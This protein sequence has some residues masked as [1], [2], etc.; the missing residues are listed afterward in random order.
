MLGQVEFHIYNNAAEPHLHTI[1]KYELRIDRY[2]NE[3]MK[4]LEENLGVNANTF[5]Q[6]RYDIKVQ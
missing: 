5:S 6:V 1:H 3:N 2:L 4:L